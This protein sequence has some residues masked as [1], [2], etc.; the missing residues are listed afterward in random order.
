M[1]IA[2]LAV[3]AFAALWF[4]AL[5]PKPAEV[6]PPTAVELAPPKPVKAKPKTGA[7]AAKA[8]AS[9][10]EAAKAA[11]PAKETPTPN[12]PKAQPA[13]AKADPAPKK[14]AGRDESS[15]IKRVLADFE[16]GKVVVLLFWDREAP[17]D[18]EVYDAVSATKRHGGDVSVRSA[19]IEKLSEYDAITDGVPVAASPSVLVF[20]RK[21]RGTV[22]T[23]LTVTSELDAAISRALARK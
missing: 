13:A 15:K 2:L 14:A 10:P 3:L 1:R 17:L 9:K 7:A 21:R 19:P 18:R 8:T 22:I 12:L 4:A 23:G 20:D 6:A 5:R 11:A 16:A